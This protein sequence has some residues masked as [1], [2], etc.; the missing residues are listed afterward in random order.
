MEGEG[1]GAVGVE[2][3]GEGLGEGGGDGEGHF[4]EASV[5]VRT[6]RL[7]LYPLETPNTT[8]WIGPAM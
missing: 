1:D 3:G 6:I 8:H 5:W 2:V 7:A 4:G